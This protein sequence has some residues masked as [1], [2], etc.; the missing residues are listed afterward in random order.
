MKTIFVSVLLVLLLTISVEI[1][2]VLPCAT[3]ASRVNAELAAGN[4]V[5]ALRLPD[6]L[7]RNKPCFCQE[8]AKAV[9]GGALMDSV[10]RLTAKGDFSTAIDL[11]TRYFDPVRGNPE[12]GHVIGGLQQD[13]VLYIRSTSDSQR[14]LDQIGTA[15]SSFQDK[16]LMDTL[17]QEEPGLLLRLA[18][19]QIE[20]GRH[21][22]CYPLIRARFASPCD[23]RAGVAG[24]PRRSCESHGVRGTSETGTKRLFKGFC[25][26][27]CECQ[28]VRWRPDATSH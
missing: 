19:S 15:R 6:E 7:S 9:L 20:K 5:L 1:W 8:E 11:V 27:Q 23:F 12:T 2:H 28:R 17:A 24:G 18:D 13:L 21:E 3:L 14:A 16:A 25:R 22:R 4:Y 10:H 26:C